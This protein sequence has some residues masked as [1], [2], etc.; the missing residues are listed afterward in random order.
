M[1]G[2]VGTDDNGL[3]GIELALDSVVKGAETQ[4]QE[5]VDALGR[6]MGDSG[7]NKARPQKMASVYLTLD[8]KIQ[9]VLEDALD[10]AMKDTK[11]ASAAVILMDPNTGAILGMANRPSFD[12]NT[13]INI[14]LP[15]GLIARFRLFTNRARFSSRLWA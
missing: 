4:Q 14:R 1:L 12:P 7:F 2:F 13:F 6:P 11:A 3:S 9:F 8:S 15:A 5:A 10:K